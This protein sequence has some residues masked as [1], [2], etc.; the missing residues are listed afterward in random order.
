VS[1]RDAIYGLLTGDA[2]LTGLLADATSVYHENAPAE[3]TFPYVVF[4][5]QVG[6][7]DWT[8]GGEPMRPEVWLV[9][10]VDRGQSAE[11]AEAIDARCETLLNDA[12]LNITGSTLL[13]LRRDQDVSFPEVDGQDTY[14]HVG[15]LYRLTHQHD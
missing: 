15:G 6:L 11:D 12:A 14:K 13:Y 2:T 10:A 4:H 8:F 7:R 5:R 1:V 3:A 9:K